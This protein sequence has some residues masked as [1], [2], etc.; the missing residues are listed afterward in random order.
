MKR[1]F[2]LRSEDILLRP[3]EL[4]DI[5]GAYRVWFNDPEIVLYNSHGRFPMTESRLIHYVQQ[6]KVDM[7]LLALAIEHIRTKKH[8]GNVSLQSLNWVDRNAEIAFLLGNKTFWGRGIMFQAGK[9]M[10]DHAFNTLN[11]HRVYCATSEANIGMQ[12]LALKLGM[13][14]EGVRKDAM[15]KNNKYLDVIEYGIIKQCKNGG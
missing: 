1:N 9:L 3:L 10:I 6:T 15:F 11:L 2:F 7:S 4:Q 5:A 12:K 8:I 13:K 14:K